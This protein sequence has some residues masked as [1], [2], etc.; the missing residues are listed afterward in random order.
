MQV[1][2][3]GL[4][5]ASALIIDSN[6]SSRSL[7][8]AQLRD[9]GVGTVKQTS[10][11]RDAR[12]LLEHGTYDIVLC[13]YHF[14]DGELSGQDLLDE[15]RREQL[16]PY[17]TIFVMV[18]GEASYSKVAEAAEAA[19]DAYLVKPYTLASL[20]DRLSHARQRKRTLKPIFDAIEAQ[21]FETAADLC[22]KRFTERSRYWL[23][24][25]RIG[26]ELLLRLSRHADARTL[27]EAI[28]E[29]RT[30]P[31][32]KL[33]VARS[34]IAAGN[35]P[36][37][38]RTLETLIGEAPDYADSYDIMGRMQMDQGEI[39]GALETYRTAAR[40]TPGCLLRGQRAG[41]LA[42]YMGERTEALKLL[43]TT[44][45]NGLRSKLF[46][47]LT[48]VLIGFMRF[49]SRDV[50]GLRYSHEA[51]QQ[52]VERDRFSER[53]RRF[54]LVYQSLREASEGR[55]A[56]AIETLKK[57][58]A[59][60]QAPDFDLEAA[61]LLIGLWVRLR[62]RGLQIEGLEAALETIGLRYCTTKSA[63]EILVAMTEG[64][65]DAA[66]KLREAHVKVFGIAETAMRHSMRGGAETAV[67]LLIE[68]G[69]ATRNAK[70]IDMASLVLKRHHDKI[71]S[72]AELEEQVTALQDRYVVPLGGAAT[73]IGHARAAGGLAL[74]V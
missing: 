65:E 14:D 13:D 49:D 47:L 50:K 3:S 10:R 6:A 60:I 56:Q 52:E 9:L 16:L 69:E 30:V 12:V 54:G 66:N 18:T 46:D 11:V 36:E 15:L 27:Y 4:E 62:K 31:W 19:L 43:E 23:Y 33:G 28:I 7:M 67:R 57:L 72:A 73:R 40:L 17:S 26:A 53:A 34:E 59:E 51:M 37:A 63:T 8:A 35:L 21:D 45:V 2:D 74:R 70:L 58:A 1:I 29:A 20:A 68:Q 61:S 44:M 24:A 48:L 5:N 39:A 38:R 42:Y 71:P 32:A 22:M 25:A 41:T 64:E 55:S